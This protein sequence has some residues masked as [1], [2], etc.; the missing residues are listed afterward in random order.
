[1]IRKQNLN[2]RVA[3][4]TLLD[5]IRAVFDKDAYAR[6]EEPGAKSYSMDLLVA[7]R[8]ELYSVDATFAPSKIPDGEIWCEGMGHAYAKG[9][10]WQALRGGAKPEQAIRAALEA[11]CRYHTGCGGEIRVLRFV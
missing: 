9:A 10:G 3:L 1:M 6:R 11:A 5:H 4:S 2:R 7:S 8:S